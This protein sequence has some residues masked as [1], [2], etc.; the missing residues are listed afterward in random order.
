MMGPGQERML[1]EMLLAL[2]CLGTV[3]A[4]GYD[5]QYPVV[6]RQEF[7]PVDIQHGQC[8]T[9]VTI[10]ED[11][12]TPGVTSHN[13]NRPLTCWYEFSLTGAPSSDYV[14]DIRFKT[15]NVGRVYNSSTCQGGYV[16]IID[17]T[18]DTAI[19]NHLSPGFFCGEMQDRRHFIS[20]TNKVKLIFHADNFTEDTYLSFF[21]RTEL[22]RALHERYGKQPE[23]YPGGRR[24]DPVGPN[25]YCER[26][27]SRCRTDSCFVQSPA[28]PGPYPRN[29]HCRYHLNV[30]SAY[31]KLYTADQ[32]VSIDGQR[33][34]SPMICPLRPLTSNPARC[35]R[36]YITI[37]DGKKEIDPKI[38]TFCGFGRYV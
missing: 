17:G 10:Y 36:D 24:G 26:V 14:I 15:F 5:D 9:T 31:I 37:Y 22:T 34:D 20:E 11:V 33:C 4:R 38:G 7:L 16:Q 27:F 28:Y 23:L 1:G 8:D 32:Q 6:S 3:I 13:Y 21:S 2:T 25:N 30:E 35:T 18:E 29:L 19:T 12:S